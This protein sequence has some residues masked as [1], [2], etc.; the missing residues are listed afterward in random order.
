MDF[1]AILDGIQ[2][3]GL[4]EIKRINA[5]AK[6]QIEEINESAEKNAEK[7]RRRIIADGRAR[8]NREVAL[9]Q[10]QAAVQ[11][12]KIHADARQKLIEEVLDNTKKTFPSIRKRK[13]Y[14]TFLSQMVEEV[15]HSITPSLLED[16]R[17]TLHFDK[18]DKKIAEDII[19]KQKYDVDVAYDLESA[20][21]CTGETEDELVTTL[22]TIESRFDRADDI[23]KQRLSVFFEE[24]ISPD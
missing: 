20:G 10:Q 19:K 12:L 9:I 14:P 8:L 1:Q 21:G 7:Q 18:R 4:Q 13:D 11:S 5:D 15:I 3:E 17:I 23:L 24:K 22:D 16:Q 2:A 6:K